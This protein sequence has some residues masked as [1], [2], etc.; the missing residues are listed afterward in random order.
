MFNSI[1]IHRRH[2]FQ[3][4]IRKGKKGEEKRKK[5]EVED[6][7]LGELEKYKDRNILL[8]TSFLFNW[9]GI[10]FLLTIFC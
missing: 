3:S 4:K 7:W 10:L 2:F 1:F 9:H 5:E 8:Y 6:E